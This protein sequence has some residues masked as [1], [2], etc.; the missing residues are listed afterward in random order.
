MQV[1]SKAV[2]QARTLENTE[3]KIRNQA[4]PHS[5]LDLEQA[6]TVGGNVRP[7]NHD[8]VKPHTCNRV[9]SSASLASSVCSSIDLSRYPISCRRYS[10][11]RKIF[12]KAKTDMDAAQR[13]TEFCL[14]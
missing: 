9:S 5:Y 10:N 3:A 14:R 8:N 2:R 7:R 6:K 11:Q 4:G 12:R 1:S 13:R